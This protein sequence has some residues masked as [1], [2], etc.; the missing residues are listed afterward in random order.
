MTITPFGAVTVQGE[1]HPI[2]LGLTIALE[3]T[4]GCGDGPG[5]QP[6]PT[7]AQP[8]TIRPAGTRIR[9]IGIAEY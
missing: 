6:A 8:V 9:D 1:S 3:E 7:N 2:G 5:L 4:D